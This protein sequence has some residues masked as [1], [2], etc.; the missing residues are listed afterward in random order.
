MDHLQQKNQKIAGNDPKIQLSQKYERL[1]QFIELCVAIRENDDAW[2]DFIEN[3]ILDDKIELHKHLKDSRLVFAAWLID[4]ADLISLEPNCQFIDFIT[5]IEQRN[6]VFIDMFLQLFLGKGIFE[7]WKKLGCPKLDHDNK[8]KM[9]KGLQIIQTGSTEGLETLFGQ[10]CLPIV[11]ACLRY[12]HF[13]LLVEK[14][15][16]FG[17]VAHLDCNVFLEAAK[18]E[19]KTILRLMNTL[20]PSVISCLTIDCNFVPKQSFTLSNIPPSDNI[21]ISSYYQA[22]EIEFD[23]EQALMKAVQKIK[24]SYGGVL[25]TVIMNNM[26]DSHAGLVKLLAPVL[27]QGASFTPFGTNPSH[28]PELLK[29]L[30]SLSGQRT[31]NTQVAPKQMV[32]KNSQPVK[33]APVHAEN[34]RESLAKRNQKPKSRQTK[35]DST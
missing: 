19:N 8:V 12:T 16:G 5:P 20:T 1:Q 26:D 24:E 21:S 6:P 35:R 33:A 11:D 31:A 7:V 4:Y 3:P 18:N 23:N 17:H 32:P 22:A 30:A 13:P 27:G 2:L 28:F 9:L 34:R 14:E 10:S 29:S 25:F 15:F